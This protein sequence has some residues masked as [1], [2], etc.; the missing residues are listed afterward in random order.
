MADPEATETPALA[1][2]EYEAIV[3][4]ASYSVTGGEG[5]EFLIFGDPQQ[6]GGHTVLGAMVNVGS[7]MLLLESDMK[8][9]T[10]EIVKGMPAKAAP[11]KL[12]AVET[13]TPAT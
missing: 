6:M 8:L 13:G 11:R 12:R 9:H 2:D 7:L 5:G 10:I 3:E 1:D 4:V